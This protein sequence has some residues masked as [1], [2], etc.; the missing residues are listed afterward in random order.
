MSDERGMPR[1]AVT[2]DTNV[3]RSI[4]A[5]KAT[6]L[7][8]R[9]R[10]HGVVGYASYPVVAEL[11]AH[12]AEP[13]DPDF[14]S[15]LAALGRLWEHCSE[16]DGSSY[17]LRSLVGAFEQMAHTLFGVEMGM[18]RSPYARL[19]GAIVQDDRS[20]EGLRPQ[21]Q[22][23]ARYAD[24]ARSAY[25][26]QLWE[27]VVQTIAPAAENWAD[28]A[29]PSKAR[30][31]VLA[32]IGEGGGRELIARSLVNQVAKFAGRTVTDEEAVPLVEAVHAYY[33]TVVHYRSLVI[34]RLVRDAPNMTKRARANGVMDTH[35]CVG[36]S[37]LARLEGLPH[38]LATDDPE[39]LEAAR[40]A[41][42]RSRLLT[43][44]EY[45]GLLD[46]DA[47]SFQSQ[48]DEQSRGA[49]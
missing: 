16:Y 1:L 44:Q 43:L 9:E 29:L 34:E 3:Y 45:E 39:I 19:V 23:V 8:E 46:M 42:S 47:P 15:A 14:R 49:T 24:E 11:L 37:P 33:A 32:E 17:T 21:L 31:R 30:A 7:R 40:R 35:V 41:D 36:T 2:F 27:R 48:L 26:A 28:L 6:K 5:A 22:Q 25:A 10:N 13:T 4:G 12:L 18:R 20:I 38:V